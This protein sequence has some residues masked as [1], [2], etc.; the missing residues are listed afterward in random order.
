MAGLHLEILR[1]ERRCALQGGKR[2]DR[3]GASLS[4][5]LL[6]WRGCGPFHA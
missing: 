4:N 1:H 3:R 5:F 2:G 6:R